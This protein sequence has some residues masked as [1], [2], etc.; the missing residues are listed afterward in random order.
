MSAV[1][2]EALQVPWAV[3]LAGACDLQMLQFL[4]HLNDG[5][6]ARSMAVAAAALGHGRV[7]P[8]GGLGWLG[9]ARRPAVPAGVVPPWHRTGGY[10]PSPLLAGPGHATGKECLTV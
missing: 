6:A 10:R 2:T 4:T 7:R 1:V 9:G 3:N 8:L 5:Q